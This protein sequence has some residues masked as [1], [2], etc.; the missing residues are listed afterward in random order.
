VVSPEKEKALRRQLDRAIGR[1]LVDRDFA[2]ELMTDPSGTLGA[3]ALD[4]V[5]AGSLLSLARVLL[6]RFWSTS[7]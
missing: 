7:R 5:H 2:D 6:D 4:D 3:P 1:A